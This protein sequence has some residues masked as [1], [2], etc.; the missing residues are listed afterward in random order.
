MSRLSSRLY[1][2]FHSVLALQ[3]IVIF[4]SSRLSFLIIRFIPKGEETEKVKLFFSKKKK[5]EIK[6]AAPAVT[7]PLVNEGKRGDS[8]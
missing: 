7:C 8:L 6:T 5:K 2:K 4:V 3:A 1:S